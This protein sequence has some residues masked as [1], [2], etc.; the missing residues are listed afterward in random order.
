[1]PAAMPVTTPD[2][3]ATAM[4]VL[5]LLQAPPVDG[6]LKVMDAPEH[7]LLLPEIGEGI[8]LTVVMNQ[9]EQLPAV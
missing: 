8:G 6:S 7:T 2:E 1:M 9:A 4:P 3:P 5:L